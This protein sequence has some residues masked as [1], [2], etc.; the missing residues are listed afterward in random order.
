MTYTQ[1]IATAYNAMSISQILMK[2]NFL[3]HFAINI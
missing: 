2:F 3:K 1:V